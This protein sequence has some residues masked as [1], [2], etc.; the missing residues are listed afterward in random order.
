[1]GTKKAVVAKIRPVSW[2]VCVSGE[3]HVDY[4]R[5]TLHQSG[6]DCSEAIREPDLQEP[7]T[8]SFVATPKA[9]SSLTAPELQAILDR[10][11]KIEVVFDA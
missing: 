7:P 8:F 4:V 5:S 2:K 11:G 10:D 6:F 3:D 9:E 1:M